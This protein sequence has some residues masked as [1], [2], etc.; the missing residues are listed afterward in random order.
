MDSLRHGMEPPGDWGLNESSRMGG[1][2]GDGCGNLQIHKVLGKSRIGGRDRTHYT[3][4]RKF[5]RAAFLGIPATT[6]VQG[7]SS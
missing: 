6:G 7:Q 1:A 2:P 4:E 5:R 3:P